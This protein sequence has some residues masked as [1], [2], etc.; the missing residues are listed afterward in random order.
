MAVDRQPLASDF[1]KGLSAAIVD[2]P[3]D[4]AARKTANTAKPYA[5]LLY[6]VLLL[7]CVLIP[8][9]FW[10]GGVLEREAT[11]FMRQYTDDRTVL[12]KVFDPHAND[13]QAYQARELSYLIDYIDANFYMLLL[14][15]FDVTFFIPLSALISSLLIVALFCIGVRKTMLNLDVLTTG[16]LLL[17]LLTSFVFVATMGVFY[18]SSKPVLAP[19]ILAFMF[20]TLRVGQ[21]RSE[22][23]NAPDRR[24]A[25]L[26]PDGLV[27]FFLATAMG[28]LDRQGFFYSLIPCGTL[29]LHCLLKRELQDLLIGAGAAAAFGQ[30]YNLLL[31]PIIVQAANGYWPDFFVQKLPFRQMAHL[32]LLQAF[33]L[34]IENAMALL[35]GMKLTGYVLMA[36]LTT[37]LIIQSIS[38]AR[39]RLH[40]GELK[41]Y[42]KTNASLCLTYG[43]VIFSLQVLMF[44][45]MIAAHPPVYDW[46]DHRYWYYPIGFLI[47]V[48]FGLTFLVNLLLPYLKKRQYRIL[49]GVLFLMVISNLLSLGYYKNLMLSSYWFGPVYRQSALLKISIRNDSPAP[50]LNAESERFYQLHERNRPRMVK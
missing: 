44:A 33:K 38:I 31:G 24:G 5:S 48:L 11:I 14:K 7:W 16:L 35:G 23:A 25:L 43:V 36:A 30:T 32:P 15:L 41:G 9:G 18:R 2:G 29:G 42:C 20:Y 12:Q 6:G 34:L 45:L 49:Q 22:R 3:A 8:A 37:H 10:D 19:V 27:V 17:L 13:F 46:I 4:V 40:R 47:T 21:K 39:R 50:E 28:L 26:T 1:L